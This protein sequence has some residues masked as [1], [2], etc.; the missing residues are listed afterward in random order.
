MPVLKNRLA[1][2]AAAT[3]PMLVSDASTVASAGA[4]DRGDDLAFATGCVV[5]RLGFAA[6]GPLVAHQI[7]N[8]KHGPP[9]DSSAG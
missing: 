2:A 8:A 5:F 3:L 4:T 1:N 6:I 9:V 7:C